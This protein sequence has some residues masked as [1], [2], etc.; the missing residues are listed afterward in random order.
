V[1]KDEKPAITH[2]LTFKSSF[3]H[4][5]KMYKE[6]KLIKS[7]IYSCECSQL[8]R[9]P[10]VLVTMTNVN[11]WP[12][13]WIRRVFF[14]CSS[15]MA[16]ENWSNIAHRAIK[17]NVY[18]F[19]CKYLPSLNF[20][21]DS[22]PIFLDSMQRHCFQHIHLSVLKHSYALGVLSSDERWQDHSCFHPR[23]G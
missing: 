4:E 6:S 2:L 18:N 10:A 20:Q 11:I 16:I 3:I 1:K 9:R 8:C 19:S 5:K 13:Q 21:I 12:H 22:N 15:N 14:C 17:R 23:Y 7:A